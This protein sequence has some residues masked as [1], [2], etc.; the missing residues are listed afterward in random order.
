MTLQHNLSAATTSAFGKKTKGTILSASLE[1]FNQ[2]G[3]HA[4][5]TAQ[6]ASA[7]EVLDGTLWYHFKAKQDLANT[8]LET[9]EVRLEEILLA[10]HASEPQM[11]VESYFMIFDALWDFR[12]LLRDPSP[13]LQSEP[14]FAAR[15]KQAYASVEKNTIYRL[16]SAYDEGLLSLSDIDI[17]S[18]AKNCVVIG[19]YWLD[20]SKVRGGSSRNRETD[21]RQAAEQVFLV[22]KP[23][24]TPKALTLIDA[25][26]IERSA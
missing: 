15:I 21:K 10:P 18:F 11:I 1:L 20:Y 3:F 19:N 22:L 14:E 12:Y 4:V 23:Y 25:S 24:L 9:L 17:D 6:I 13:I 8:H 2:R 5:S 7:S 16:K 26:E